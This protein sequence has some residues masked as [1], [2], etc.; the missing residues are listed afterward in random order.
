MELGISICLRCLLASHSL[1][2]CLIPAQGTCRCLLTS[3]HLLFLALLL[4]SLDQP[5]L[6]SCRRVSMG[7]I[8][9]YDDEPARQRSL[10]SYSKLLLLPAIL[11]AGSYALSS[12]FIGTSL[13]ST[14]LNAE[15]RAACPVQPDPIVPALAF[16]V[17]PS[18]RS[19]AADRLA[20]AV[21]V[22]SVNFDNIGLVTEDVSFV[23]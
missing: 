10:P 9:L 8:A 3:A 4:L 22:A 12:V 7:A 11:L 16:D 5:A 23:R 14:N 6:A 15:L 21:R 19:E 13:S 18:F 2:T 1:R 17:E 20:Q